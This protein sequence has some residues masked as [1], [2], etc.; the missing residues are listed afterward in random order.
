MFR[1]SDLIDVWF[2]SGS[3]PYAQLH[4]PFENASEF[5]K[6]FPA[7]F[8]AEGV[9]QTRGW[10]FTLHAI[11]SMLFDK[12]AFKN[13]VSNGLVLDKNGNKMSKRLG[14]GVDPFETINKYGADAT[15]WYLMTNSQPWENLKFDIDGIGEVQRKFFGTLYNTYNFFALY[16]NIDEFDYSAPDI[17]Y[18]ERPE[19]DRWILSEL[20][21]LVKNVDS[22]FSDYEPTRAGRLIQSFVDEHLSN[23]YVRL[24]RRRF[25]KSGEV[26]DKLSAYQTLYTCL[27]TIAKIM[28]PIAPFFAE[29]LY[30]DLNFVAGRDTCD[31]VHLCDFPAVSEAQI[32]SDL[33][34]RMELAQK[35]CSIILSLRKKTNLRVRQPLSRVLIPVLDKRFQEQIE[36]VTALI[37]SEVNV[38]Q[39][40]FLTDTSLLAKKIKPNFKALGPRYGKLMKEIAAV[41]VELSQEQINTLEGVGV[42]LLDIAGSQVELLRSDVEIYTEDVA[43]FAV[44]TEGT[45]TVALDIQ[46]TEELKAE[47]LSRE[48]INRIQ[49]LIIVDVAVPENLK[50]AIKQ[51]LDY[52]CS[53]IL[54]KEFNFSQDTLKDVVDLGEGVSVGIALTKV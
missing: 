46:L 45:L 27:I 29:R 43:G 33:E 16:A 26:Q 6:L 53:E 52:I 2:D 14:N 25:W 1:E 31:S 17:P 3:M 4:Y 36:K 8:I 24:S 23:W 39:I 10:F 30:S 48:L 21:T 32:D 44:A 42:L 7:D 19:L 41:A 37:L 49:N 38:K 11:A 9:D 40:E 47:G 20:G 35:I 54:A 12:V 5:D 15:R 34:E 50:L 51:N 28:S 22:A 18:K 13:V